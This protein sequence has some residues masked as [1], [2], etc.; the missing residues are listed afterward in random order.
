MLIITNECIKKEY[1][2][3]ANIPEYYSEENGSKYCLFHAP[4]EIRKKLGLIDLFN[5]T[6]SQ[7]NSGALGGIHFDSSMPLTSINLE[8]NSLVIKDCVFDHIVE[9]DRRKMKLID[10]SG[11]IFN[12]KIIFDNSTFIEGA[13]FDNAVLKNLAS[14]K[15]CTFQSKL[16]FSKTAYTILDF[17]NARFN[18]DCRF[19]FLTPHTEVTDT[20]EAPCRLNFD[21]ISINAVQ[22]VSF[23]MCNIVN[24]VFSPRGRGVLE[25]LGSTLRNS[26]FL[27]A[28]LSNCTFNRVDLS[29]SFLLGAKVS[30]TRFINCDFAEQ[31]YIAAQRIIL[32]DEVFNVKT[33]CQGGYKTFANFQS[34]RISSISSL[35]E[36]YCALKNKFENNKDFVT[37]DKFY[38]SEMEMRR[39]SLGE[40]QL[41]KKQE[42][43][44]NISKSDKFK[45]FLRTEIFSF[46]PWYKYFTA[47]G[48]SYL[49][50]FIWIILTINS[51]A[52]LYMFTGLSKIKYAIGK[53]NNFSIVAGDFIDAFFYA[54]GILIP[55]LSKSF[56]DGVSSGTLKLSAIEFILMWILIPLFVI[57]LKRHFK[58]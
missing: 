11:A 9:L 23:H 25:F 57:A 53:Q 29:E 6:L 15:K 31:K 34:K 49:R 43:S 2:S 55:G 27:N 58:R 3:C 19:S 28:D 12:D 17:E 50:G 41:M 40:T 16:T 47:Y 14:F 52:I 26:S 46:Y 39:F 18:A 24:A 37:A 45:Y 20:V 7:I 35:E 56:F 38:F 48:T 33:F 22:N 51:F 4:T 8:F 1:H 54:V 13:N 44:A 30:N 10:A 5:K 42:P 36:T 21:N 32:F